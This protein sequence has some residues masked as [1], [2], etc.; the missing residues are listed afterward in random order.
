VSIEGTR[1]YGAG[2][3]R[4]VIAAGLLV[5]ECEQPHRKARR[6]KG[7]SDP[8][9]AHLAVLTALRLDADRLPTARADGDR[10]ALRILLSARH[11]LTTTTIGQTNRLR[12]LLRDGED[13][14]RQIARGALTPGRPGPAPSTPSGQP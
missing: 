5:C 4:A 10:E 8:I 14:D 11:E 9:D 3:A 2:L 6:G 7:K 12:A 13:T 1:S